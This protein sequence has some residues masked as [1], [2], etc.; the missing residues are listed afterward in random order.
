[1]R[2]HL[3]KRQTKDNEIIN[4]TQHSIFALTS[5][6][7]LQITKTKHRPYL[8]HVPFRGALR[9]KGR[10]LTI[11]KKKESAEAILTRIKYF[12]ELLMRAHIFPCFFKL[13]VVCERSVAC[14]W[15]SFFMKLLVNSQCFIWSAPLQSPEVWSKYQEVSDRSCWDIT[16]TLG[17]CALLCTVFCF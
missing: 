2:V 11:T 12:F 16:M 1:M 4:C 17:F 8:I 3:V 9:W 10:I 14:V 15:L 7:Q 6:W 13:R 5:N